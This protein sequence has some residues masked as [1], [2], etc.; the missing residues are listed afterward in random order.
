MTTPE[1]EIYT[2]GDLT[3]DRV[4]KANGITDMSNM[5]IV[6]DAV[7]VALQRAT[8]DDALERAA[9]VAEDMRSDKFRER[10]DVKY[11][12][13]MYQPFRV[14]AA[15]N[16][17]IN[18]NAEDTAAAIRALQSAPAP[19]ALQAALAVP[20]VRALRDLLAEARGDLHVYIGTE[21]PEQ[22]RAKYPSVQRQFDRDMELCRRIDAALAPLR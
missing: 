3:F 12:R 8:S 16:D 11:G 9:Q 20:E 4:F 14:E 18:I 22:M 6:M 1:P 15:C 5:Q 17:A 21:Y 19:T 13:K 10:Y 2:I 7:E